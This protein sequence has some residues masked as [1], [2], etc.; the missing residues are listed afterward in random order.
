[1]S[2]SLTL[3]LDIAIIALLV[4]TIIYAWVL[5][6]RLADLRRNRD[7]LTRLI[8][9]FNEATQRAEA[10]VPRLRKAADEAGRSLQDRVEKAQILRD[11]LAF[12][13]DR[14][15]SMAG[16]LDSRSRDARPAATET[17]APSRGGAR[18]PDPGADARTVQQAIAAASLPQPRSLTNRREAAQGAASVP[19]P[20]RAAS[21]S[22][23]P[24]AP[25]TPATPKARDDDDFFIED[26]RSEAE[27]E[28]LRALQSAR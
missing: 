14:A 19:P 15:E 1:M 27:R 26:E 5:N 6:S 2:L 13:V 9:S 28:L 11:D 22:A 16:R 23:P 21:V 24:A 10:G 17:R 3:I 8:A 4:P 12:M 20:P 25:A 7:D 18:T